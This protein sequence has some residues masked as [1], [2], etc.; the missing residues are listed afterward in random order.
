[1]LPRGQG[2][3]HFIVLDR[4]RIVD[5]GTDDEMMGRESSYRRLVEAPLT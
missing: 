5:S 1:L 2:D 3:G 4:G